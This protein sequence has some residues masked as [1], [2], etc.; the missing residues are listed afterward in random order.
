[1]L[2]NLSTVTYSLKA[3]TKVRYMSL[4]QFIAVLIGNHIEDMF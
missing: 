1:M 4:K 3:K 2:K